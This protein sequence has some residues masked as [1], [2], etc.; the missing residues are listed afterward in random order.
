MCVNVSS[1]KRIFSNQSHYFPDTL[2]MSSCFIPDIFYVLWTWGLGLIFAAFYCTS[3][4][5]ISSLPCWIPCK[6]VFII[7]R[8]CV[9]HLFNNL[10][11][12]ANT[13]V[14]FLGTAFWFPFLKWDNVFYLTFLSLH[15]RVSITNFVSQVCHLTNNKME[16]IDRL[17]TELEKRNSCLEETARGTVE[18]YG[19][20]NSCAALIAL[21][22]M[23]PFI[24]SVDVV[25]T[26]EAV[27]PFT[28]DVLRK[29]WPV[30][31]VFS[32]WICI[33]I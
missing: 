31:V 30:T 23:F 13:L 6:V 8:K 32:C 5:R 33:Y 11:L 21:R 4:A 18:I 25:V 9:L 10:C 28:R 16:E 19:M 3:S 15:V 14:C 17:N 2:C 24:R 29:W 26:S 7:N 22:F 1:I 20:F 27:L 12:S